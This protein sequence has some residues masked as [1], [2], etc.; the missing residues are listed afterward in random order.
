MGRFLQP[1][2][3]IALSGEL[4]SG[5]T[6][7]VKGLAN[8]LGGD[9]RYP[10]SSPSFVLVNEYP[11]RIPLYHIDLYR[12]SKGTDLEEMGLEEYFYGNGVTAIEWAEKARSLVP[13]RHIWIDIQWTG[14]SNRTLVVRAVGKHNICILETIHKQTEGFIL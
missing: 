9:R 5:K 6:V 7:F 10:I 3:L 4:G 14:P 1:G 2:S 11:G 8:G 12:L 13:S